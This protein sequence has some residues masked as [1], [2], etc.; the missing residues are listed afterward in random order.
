MSHAG[1]IHDDAKNPIY[2]NEPNCS[3]VAEIPPQALGLA[4]G[5]GISEGKTHP[6][7]ADIIHQR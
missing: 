1:P 7:L 4:A 2:R 3:V 6:A 5:G